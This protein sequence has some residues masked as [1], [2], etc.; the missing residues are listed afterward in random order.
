[1]TYTYTVYRL[2]NNEKRIDLQTNQKWRAALEAR[3]LRPVKKPGVLGHASLGII[4]G[5]TE[6]EMKVL[7]ST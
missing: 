1:M 5:F 7:W 2:D 3:I 6:E 4:E